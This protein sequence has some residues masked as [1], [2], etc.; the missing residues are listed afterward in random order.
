M[1]GGG[2]GKCEEEEGKGTCFRSGLYHGNSGLL[3]D[4]LQGKSGLPPKS[5]AGSAAAYRFE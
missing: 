4:A 2:S 3:G 1:T 5:S